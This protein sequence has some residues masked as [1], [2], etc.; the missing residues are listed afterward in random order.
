MTE[1]IIQTKQCKSCS[2]T[3]HIT[4]K[5]MEFYDKI[6]PVFSYPSSSPKIGENS[7]SIL[8]GVGGSKKFPIPTP[9]LCPDCR[10][11]RRL[12]WRNERKLY[13]RTCD[14]TGKPIISIYSADKP[15]KVYSQD[16]RRSDNRDPMKYGKDFDFNRWFFE[17]FDELMKGVPQLSLNWHLS[18]ENSEYV[19]YIVHSKNMYMCF[20]WWYNENV[21]YSTI[22]MYTKNSIEI[23]FSMK[24]EFCYELSYSTNC[25]SVFYWYNCIDCSNSYFVENCNGC[26]YCFGC[27]WLQNK[28]YFI[29]NKQFTK[30]DYENFINEY[31]RNKYEFK[32]KAK[33]FLSKSIKSN[34]NILWSTECLG[35]NIFYSKNCNQSNNI[36]KWE[37]LKYCDRAL[38]MTDS[39]DSNQ[40]WVNVSLWYEVMTWSVN[41]QKIVF[42]SIIRENCSNLYYCCNISNCSHC[43]G[44]VWLR[45]KS[46]CIFNKQYTPEQYNELVPKIIE[47]MK[48]DPDWSGQVER[49]EFFPISISP[50][51]YNETVA[52]EY[53]PLTKTQIM[54]KWLNRKD[55][56]DKLV[57]WE[58]YQ[59]LDIEVYRNDEAKRQ[60]LLNS[61]IKCEVSGRPFRIIK[62]ELDFYL[63]HNLPIPTK[64]PDTRHEERM[65]LRN[66][67]KLFTRICDCPN[68]AENHK[69]KWTYQSENFTLNTKTGK[70]WLKMQTTYS[71]DRE[72][73]V[74]CEEC[75]NREVYG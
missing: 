45:N 2:V 31:Y 34:L 62:Q 50:F 68:C 36:H 23:L 48:S 20:G 43:F 4:D 15:Y 26:E 33:S 58:W 24:N 12:A 17:Q 1:N 8:E 37:N 69:T 57:E 75:Y 64:H 49:W 42:C 7:P 6:S 41:L 27:Y 9:T 67:R 52:M 63:K 61:I 29:Y 65:K 19:N 59:P 38:F 5:D 54:E 56:E 53:F 72:E 71:P 16:F 18:N 46:Y 30:Q 39:M 21:F 11:Q 55:P 74:Y 13:R 32:R 44:C 35:N 40:I 14:A 66:P 22:P 51:A 47:K 60:E 25:Y 28:K 73:I 10:Q 3:F 70:E